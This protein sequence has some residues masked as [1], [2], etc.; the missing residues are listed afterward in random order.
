MLRQLLFLC[1][2]CTI[3]VIL[4]VWRCWN[5][6]LNAAQMDKDRLSPSLMSRRLV[7]IISTTS[8]SVPCCRL[9]KKEILIIKSTRKSFVLVCGSPEHSP[10]T[11]PLVSGGHV[12]SKVTAGLQLLGWPAR[13]RSAQRLVTAASTPGNLKPSAGWKQRDTDATDSRSV[14]TDIMQSPQWV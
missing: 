10:S 6:F 13:E 11:G 8:C 14:T 7:C 3:F 2:I 5:K 1:M 4:C 9:E 12:R